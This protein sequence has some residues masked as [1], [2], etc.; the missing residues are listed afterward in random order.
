MGW[1]EFSTWEIVKEALRLTLILAAGLALI[2]WA[3][4]LLGAL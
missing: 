1:V 4:L 2:T 3:A